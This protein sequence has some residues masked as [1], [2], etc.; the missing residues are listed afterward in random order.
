MKSIKVEVVKVR[1]E[2]S[3]ITTL[4][5]DKPFDFKPG[6]Y[7]S[8]FKPGSQVTSGK[9]YSI[10]SLPSD[11]LMSLSIKD[12]G[13]EFSSYLCSRKVGDTI[14]ISQPQGYFNPETDKPLVGITAG[15]GLGPIWSV[16]GSSS[17]D[18][19]K[20]LFYS[21]RTPELTMFDEELDNSDIKVKHFSTRQKVKE[22]GKWHNGR[23]DVADIV[24]QVPDD[25]HFL[26]CG[27]TNMVQDIWTKLQSHGVN[28][29]RI[30]AEPFLQM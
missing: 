21:H 3:E 26:V 24:K 25:A 11:D 6:Q 15:C 13:G 29:M 19:S 28:E 16:M 23:F 12:V 2:N 7:L 22:D 9:F 8:V 20:H 14:E 17:P 10:S 5:F 18:Q 30:S 27:S 1:Q 4:Y